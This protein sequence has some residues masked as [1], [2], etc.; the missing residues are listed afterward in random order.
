[1]DVKTLLGSLAMEKAIGRGTGS[2]RDPDPNERPRPSME[3]Q[4]QKQTQTTKRKTLT[5]AEA[6]SILAEYPDANLSAFDIEGGADADVL[7]GEEAGKT[8]AKIGA[9]LQKTKSKKRS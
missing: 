3:E 8:F 7:A 2:N 4:M 6:R 1:M 5:E 9:K